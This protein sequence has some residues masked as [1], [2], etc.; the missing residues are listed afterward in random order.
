MNRRLFTKLL[1]FCTGMLSLM[2]VRADEEKTGDSAATDVSEPTRA[3]HLSPP[4]DNTN[5]DRSRCR[6]V[7]NVTDYSA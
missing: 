3:S 1:V 7:A 5:D 2:S 6:R 4:S